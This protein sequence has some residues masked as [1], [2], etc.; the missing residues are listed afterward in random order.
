MAL[1]WIAD[2]CGPRMHVRPAL[3]VRAS[4]RTRQPWEFL[5]LFFDNYFTI[6]RL[7]R[8]APF[9][10]CSTLANKFQVGFQRPGRGITRTWR[11]G[12]YTNY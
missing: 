9:A 10:P 11:T 8:L 2:F 7:R 4:A 1:L 3:Q 12:P 5:A 6:E